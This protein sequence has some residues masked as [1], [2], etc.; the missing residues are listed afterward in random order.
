MSVD[1]FDMEWRQLFCQ[2][3]AHHGVAESTNA[4]GRG[5]STL[6]QQGLQQLPEVVTIGGEPAHCPYKLIVGE[7][8]KKTRLFPENA[9]RQAEICLLYTSDAADD[10]L[11]VD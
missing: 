7:R 3:G 2:C 1:V 4:A 5:S 6:P 10:L 9:F 11:C 8:L